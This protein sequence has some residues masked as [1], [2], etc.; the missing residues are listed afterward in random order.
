M[1]VNMITRQMI[2]FFSYILYTLSIGMFHFK[3]WKNSIPWGPAF[4]LS[5]GP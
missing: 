1:E 4:A 3:A 5:S 2:P